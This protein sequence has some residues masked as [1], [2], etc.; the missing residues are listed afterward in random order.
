[1]AKAKEDFDLLGMIPEMS[2]AQL[3]EV[4]QAAESARAQK[5]EAEK[6]AF[7]DRMRAEAEKLGLSLESLIA[8]PVKDRRVRGAGT[9]TSPKVK[10]RD[11]ASGS[12]WSGRGRMAAKFRDLVA[13]GHSLD[14]YLV[15]KAA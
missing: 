7:V 14:E 5:I 2:V 9:R 15:D 11:P 8:G 1:M 3:I 4:I 12:E 13:Q 10:Y 6:S